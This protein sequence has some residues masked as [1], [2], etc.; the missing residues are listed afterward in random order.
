[1]SPSV[2][3]LLCCLSPL[4]FTASVKNAWFTAGLQAGWTSDALTSTDVSLLLMSAY[5]KYR[6]REKPVTIQ[7]KDQLTTYRLTIWKTDR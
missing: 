5:V 3:V 7:K 4:D 6:Y 1:M 2:S